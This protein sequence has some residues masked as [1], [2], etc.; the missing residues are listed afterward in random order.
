MT[1]VWCS[2]YLGEAL[3]TL[4]PGLPE[5]AYQEALRQ[6]VEVSVYQ[7]PLQINQEKDKIF[8]DGVLVSFRNDKGQRIKQRLRIIDFENPDNNHFLAVREMW[9][10]GVLYRR[11][12]DVIGFIN[13]LCQTAP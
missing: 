5:E 13:G 7:S 8:K 6:I 1:G 11:R 12:P 2:R 10:K 4:N 9:V 3:V